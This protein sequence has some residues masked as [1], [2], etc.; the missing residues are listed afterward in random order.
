MSRRRTTSQRASSQDSSRLQKTSITKTN[1]LIMNLSESIHQGD[2]GATSKQLSMKRLK[3]ITKLSQK[4]VGQTKLKC[5]CLISAR[6]TGGRGQLRAK[7]GK[8]APNNRKLVKE[9]LNCS[10]I[11]AKKLLLMNSSNIGRLAGR[12]I[13]LTKKRPHLMSLLEIHNISSK[14]FLHTSC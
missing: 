2:I 7:S 10:V 11:L 4:V 13:L 9:I 3:L 8:L 6:L 5:S 1:L 14:M 12:L